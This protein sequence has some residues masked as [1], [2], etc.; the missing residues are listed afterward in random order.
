M[1]EMKK[2]WQR[3]KLTILLRGRP[4][5]MVLAGCK[6]TPTSTGASNK[7]NGCYAKNNCAVRDCQVIAPS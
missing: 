3:P 7:N 5:E 1:L 6:M 2:T 4:E